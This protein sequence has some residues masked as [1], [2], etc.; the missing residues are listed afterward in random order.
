[1]DGLRDSDT[2]QALILS[3]PTR[4]HDALARALEFEAAKNRAKGQVRLRAVEQEDATGK[5][6]MSEAALTTLVNKILAR[7]RE[8]RCWSCEQV[9]HVQC[10]CT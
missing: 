8:I 10:K 1:M 4:L 5:G 7:K 9:G 3:G 6:L 2:R